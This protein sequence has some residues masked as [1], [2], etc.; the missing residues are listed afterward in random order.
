MFIRRSALEKLGVRN[1]N[2]KYTGDIDLSFRLALAGNLAHVPHFLATHRVHSGAAST[3]ARGEVM[4]KE[5]LRL[6]ESS[7][8]SPLL[9]KSLAHQHRKILANA[10]FSA[11][12]F[13]LKNSPLKWQYNLRALFM[14][15]DIVLSRFLKKCVRSIKNP[16]VN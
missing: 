1:E 4:A 14:G 9:P 13:C 12:R 15:S 8:W 7:L 6:V 5:V 2:L 16:F 10:Y 11:S 3:V